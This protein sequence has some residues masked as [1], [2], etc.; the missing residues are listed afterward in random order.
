MADEQKPNWV[1]N[2]LAIPVVL[3][4]ISVVAEYLLPRILEE[5]RELSYSIDR[6]ISDLYPD[7]HPDSINTLLRVTFWNSGDEDLEIVPV[8]IVFQNPD[9]SFRIV[10]YT[11]RTIPEYE[12]GER[13]EE[14]PDSLSLRLTYGN[15]N[16]GN[17][18]SV[19]IVYRG[20]AM[21]EVFVN[22]KDLDV[23]RVKNTDD[24]D[25]QSILKVP[26]FVVATALISVLSVALSLLTIK[27]SLRFKM[28]RVVD[29]RPPEL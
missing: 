4:L 29:M 24:A 5:D 21:P 3:T 20:E 1:R 6:P 25:S 10:E 7:R 27:R 12:F 16:R 23:K 2:L 9:S 28:G 11:N 8:R 17:R 13:G 15:L 19:F 26:Y 18:D 22:V 14:R